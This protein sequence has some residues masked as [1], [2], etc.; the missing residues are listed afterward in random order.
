MDLKMFQELVEIKTNAIARCSKDHNEIITTVFLE[1]LKEKL[2]KL[3]EE[4]VF[5]NW[6]ISYSNHHVFYECDGFSVINTETSQTLMAS[7][8]HNKLNRDSWVVVKGFND[9]NNPS[10][11]ELTDSHCAIMQEIDKIIDELD[12]DLCLPNPF[13]FKRG[14]MDNCSDCSEGN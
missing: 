5:K 7:E 14:N 12:A 10:F 1:Y 8:I 11:V 13:V 4:T 6:S 3:V 2:S 9:T